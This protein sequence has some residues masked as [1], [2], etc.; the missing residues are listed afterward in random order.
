MHPGS[1]A[2]ARAEGGAATSVED[3][4]G[5][6]IEL[7]VPGT[8]EYLSLIRLNAGSIAARLDVTLDE[9]EDLELAVDELCLSLLGGSASGGRLRL[10]I[11][12]G[13]DLIDVRC[14]LLDAP[15]KPEHEEPPVVTGLPASLSWQILD[16]LVDE[17]G[18]DTE[19]GVKVAWLRKRRQRVLPQR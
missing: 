17:H 3:G 2:I 1:G 6:Y 8:P 7:D 15:T 9:L 13:D 5:E 4:M 11:G 18:A 14:R 10:R 16:S 12:W 19:D